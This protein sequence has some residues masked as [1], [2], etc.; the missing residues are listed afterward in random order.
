MLGFGK[1]GGG[2]A[3]DLRDVSLELSPQSHARVVVIAGS[4]E[5]LAELR[6]ADFVP[7]GVRVSEL[8][9][10]SLEQMDA[11][12]AAYDGTGL[13]VVDARP[14]FGGTQA[15]AFERLFLHLADGDVWI[16]LRSPQVPEGKRE[17]L[18]ELAD[19]FQDHGPQ[20]VQKRWREHRRSTGRVE[21]ASPMVLLEKIRPHLL[22][23]REAGAV[24]LLNSREP[25]LQVS[26]I[27]SLAAGTVRSAAM[28]DVGAAPKPAFPEELAYP[29][30]QVRRYD[31]RVALPGASVVVH[32][33]SVLPDSFRWHLAD[34]PV[35]NR[36]RDVD[37]RFARPRSGSIM[38]WEHLAGS[39]Y[40][41][42]YNNPG[43]FGHLMTEAV[44]KMWGWDA[45]KAADPSLKILCREHPK[46]PG[47]AAGRLENVLLPAYGV[48][49]ADIVWATGPVTV[50]HL[51]GVTPLWHNAP[52]YYVNPA[53]LDDW[54]RLRDGLPQVTV[55][56]QPKIFV[57]RASDSNRFCR[58]AADVESL[59][60]SRGFAVIR[61]ETF[62]IPEQAAV[63]A[64]ARV[65]AGFG[66]SGMFNLLYADALEHVVVL[67]HSA[68]WG[69]SEHLFATAHGVDSHF[70]WSDP[71]AGP[72]ASSY[73][74]H[75]ADWDFDFSANREALESLLGSL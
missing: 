13:M 8:V 61:P 63:F 62:T 20:G 36:L 56:P 43:H 39:Y 40:F 33:R 35:T 53:L 64:Q 44:A 54:R 74:A 60:V 70:F 18:V 16:A 25:E 67:N 73:Q 41:F 37:E 32:G 12:L 47:S 15:R 19:R 23:V 48:D 75:Q 71:D 29:E 22:K 68:Y 2:L 31:G 5:R 50:D 26:E 28:T 69:R 14:S 1:R 65:V 10:L 45:A 30:A 38:P 6:V 3:Q 4:P 46:R 66:G 27:A 55:A 11:E 21:V 7:D 42:A 51:V 52:P 49:P 72:E 17:R 34:D 24:E 9:A 59:F 57:T 58:N